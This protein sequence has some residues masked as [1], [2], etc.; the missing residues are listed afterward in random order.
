[1]ENW[2]SLHL[3]KLGL[4]TRIQ[5]RLSEDTHDCKFILFLTD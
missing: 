1:M 5:I 2:D 3:M 4:R